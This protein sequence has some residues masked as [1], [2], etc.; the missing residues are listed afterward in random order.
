MIVST[1]GRYALAVMMDLAEH[2]TGEYLLLDDIASRQGI[3][4]K[5][6]E[7]IMAVLS[8]GGVVLSL[9]GRGGGY[10]LSKAPD[11]YTVGDILKLTEGSLAP[12]SCA[13]GACARAAE[14][15]MYPMW[16]KLDAMIGDFFNGITIADLLAGENAADHYVI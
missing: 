8:K 5:Y 7:G 15:R 14:C 1:K 10:K 11:A 6:L 9:R 4:E 13:E 2:N 16:A 12:V 3:S